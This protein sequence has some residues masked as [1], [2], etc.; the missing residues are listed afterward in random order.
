MT[1][2]NPAQRFADAYPEVF[3]PGTDTAGGEVL[4]G[5]GADPRIGVI[6]PILPVEVRDR[7]NDARER[8]WAAMSEAEQA[9]AMLAA[10]ERRLGAGRRF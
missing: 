8:R 4:Y 10:S 6:P 7:E 9:A 5:T 2:P 1:T 3:G